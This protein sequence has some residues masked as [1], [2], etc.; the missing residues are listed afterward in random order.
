MLL[1]SM[2]I[3]LLSLFLECNCFQCVPEFVC[4]LTQVAELL[5]LQQM[6]REL[7]SHTGLPVSSA[8]LSKCG[9]GISLA[10]K[11][12]VFP[13]TVYQSKRRL[14]Q[15]VHPKENEHFLQMY[16]GI[17]SSES[18]IPISPCPVLPCLIK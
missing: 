2:V 15:L 4:T 16:I 1:T 3:F 11:C 8:C 5:L 13:D 7:E 12:S 6:V 17:D 10:A 14:S 9:S 18:V